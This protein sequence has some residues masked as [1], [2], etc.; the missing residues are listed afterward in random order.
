MKYILFGLVIFGLW[1]TAPMWMPDRTGSKIED[2]PYP[3]P[4]VSLSEKEKKQKAFIEKFGHKPRIDYKSDTP[5][6]I[7]EFWKTKYKHP[8][9]IEALRCTPLKKTDRGWMTIC[10]FHIYEDPNRAALQ[11]EEY[12]IQKGKVS[13]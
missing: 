5:Y 3:A 9:K 4:K 6:V 7:K 12:Y 8:E 2:T 13:Q 10:N 11:Q 1:V